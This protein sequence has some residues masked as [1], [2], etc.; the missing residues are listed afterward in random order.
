MLLSDPVTSWGISRITGFSADGE[1]HSLAF[2]T[3]Y[4]CPEK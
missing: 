1:N 2:L 3:V 4:Y